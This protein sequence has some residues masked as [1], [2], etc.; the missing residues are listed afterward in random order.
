MTP[1]VIVIHP[2]T[3]RSRLT[4]SLS[5]SL[6]GFRSEEARMGVSAILTVVPSARMHVDPFSVRHSVDVS[7]EVFAPPIP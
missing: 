7:A 2:T 4:R 6:H 1:L 3:L 5:L